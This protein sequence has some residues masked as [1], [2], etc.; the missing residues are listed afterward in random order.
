MT[1]FAI[2]SASLNDLHD[3]LEV[4]QKII[5]VERSF[6]KE[7]KTKSITYCDLKALVLSDQAEVVVAEYDN[8]I[9]GSGYA[10]IRKSKSYMKHS[11]HSYLGFMYVEPTFRGK[12]VNKM[13]IDSLKEWSKSQKI[14]HFSLE[15]YAD[16]LSAI[17]AYEKTGFRSNLVEMTMSLD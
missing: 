12:G 16:N 8:K 9:V 14:F 5:E 11:Y 13:V 2:R 7:L 4:E 10:E 15:V 6:D 1:G 3:L 17:K